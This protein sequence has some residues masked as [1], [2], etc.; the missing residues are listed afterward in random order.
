MLIKE[1]VRYLKT[2]D[3]PTPTLHFIVKDVSM[4]RAENHCSNK[5]PCY[6]LRSIV[7]FKLMVVERE[8]GHNE[9]SKAVHLE[10]CE[11][12][13]ESNDSIN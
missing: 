12:Y 8:A 10:K 5:R 4:E 2:N 7:L 9:V 6:I 1:R 3:K 11:R 13:Y